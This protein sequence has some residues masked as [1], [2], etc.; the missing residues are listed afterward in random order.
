[1]PKLPFHEWLIICLLV[2]TLSMLAFITLI[3]KNDVLP[4]TSAAHEPQAQT[5]Q[6]A[7]NGAVAKEGSYDLA[8]GAV[9]KELLDKAQP[10]PEADLNRLKPQSK[11]RNGQRIHVPAKN[12][13]QKW[14][15]SSNQLIHIFN[16]AMLNFPDAEIKKLFG[17]PCAFVNGN[18]FIK[19]HQEQ[20]AIRLSS[21]DRNA[22][23][24]QKIGSVFAPIQ[25]RVMKEYIALSPEII[26]NQDQLVEMIAKSYLFVTTLPPKEKK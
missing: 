4:P 23:L 16:E 25:G 20:F 14:T 5:I 7:I 19:L 11:L 18:M 17:C 10:L 15:K 8:K 21:N 12:Q 9:L 3:W 22:A 6:V 13:K 2:A 24:D 26:N 1:M